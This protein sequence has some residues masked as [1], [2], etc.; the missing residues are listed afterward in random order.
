[1]ANFITLD[2]IDN[3][4]MNGKYRL[5]VT[6]EYDLSY[7]ENYINDNINILRELLEQVNNLIN[8]IN[9]NNIK[10]RVLDWSKYLVK[11]YETNKN[12]NVKE[13]YEKSPYSTPSKAEYFQTHKYAEFI[14]RDFPKLTSSYSNIINFM[15]KVYDEA[16]RLT[17]KGGIEI[18][19]AESLFD[20]CYVVKKSCSKLGIHCPDFMSLYDAITNDP[21]NTKNR[22][23]FD[24]DIIED[25]ENSLKS[26]IIINAL[27]YTVTTP[28]FTWEGPKKY[29]RS[30]NN[31]SIA[32]NSSY[33]QRKTPIR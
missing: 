8:S 6:G 5:D 13:E 30:I 17:N 10:E 26:D 27:P 20:I 25:D 28:Y 23:L 22:E 3:L 33:L 14:E 16:K 12:K 9:D 32:Y 31:A 18:R 11:A 15:Y 24:W 29:E 1:M 7:Y 19:N 21:Y 2:D 4:A